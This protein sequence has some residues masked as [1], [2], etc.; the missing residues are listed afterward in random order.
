M[1]I[2]GSDYDGTL[3][4][5]GIDEKKRSAI[6][7]WRAAGNLFVLVSG[8][9]ACNVRQLHLDQQFGCD[10]FIGSNGA[11]ILNDAQEVVHADCCDM[12][13]LV[14]LI[15]HMLEMGCPAALVHAENFW[16]YT[17]SHLEAAEREP[18]C[19]VETMPEIR[20]YTQVTTWLPTEA[21]A[22]AVAQN[23]R[24]H[25]GEWFN[26]LQ[27]GTSVDIVRSGVN[28]A[29]GLTHLL[30]LVGAGHDDMITVGDNINDSDMLREFR[31]YAMENGVSAVKELA[32]FVTPG[33][34]ELIR[35]ELQTKE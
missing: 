16:F 28:K 8:R 10:F 17:Y 20:Y 23:I 30:E 9:H 18:A 21:E 3:N 12:Q 25:F 7:A 5:N 6:A 19:T 11:V 4:H 14:P 15:R 24:E 29:T 22:V 13:M 32:D 31:S 33:V 2:I 34:A 27:N 1:K 35:Q 26:P